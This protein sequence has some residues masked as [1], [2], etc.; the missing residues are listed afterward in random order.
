[1]SLPCFDLSAEDISFPEVAKNLVPEE[2]LKTQRQKF[3]EARLRSMVNKGAKHAA[4]RRGQVKLNKLAV[5]TKM[6]R[7]LARQKKNV[8]CGISCRRFE[9]ARMRAI[10]QGSS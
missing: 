10:L 4:K 8:S 2:F 1:M 3:E 9:L 5:R 7:K 6:Q